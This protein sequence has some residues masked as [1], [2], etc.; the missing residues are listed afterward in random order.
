MSKI[1]NPKILLKKTLVL[2]VCD[3]N[4]HNP[5]KNNAKKCYDNFYIF[6]ENDLGI[7]SCSIIIEQL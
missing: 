2:K 7:F 6:K 4:A 5:E 3:D 1:E